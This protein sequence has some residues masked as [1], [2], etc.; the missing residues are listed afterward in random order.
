M[1]RLLVLFLIIALS[2]CAQKEAS[3]GLLTD[4]SYPQNIRYGKDFTIDVLLENNFKRDVKNV[5]I[6]LENLDILNF[7]KIQNCNGKILNNGCLVEKI[8][9]GDAVELNFLLNAPKEVYIPGKD[10][11]VEPKI[12]IS[13][14]F[15]GQTVIKAPII[16]DKYKENKDLKKFITEGPIMVDVS[17]SHTEEQNV[18]R[19][20]SI[21]VM[22]VN[23][24]DSENENVIKKD[25]FNIKLE[26]F[27]VYNSG[28]D[29]GNCDFEIASTTQ[30][31][32]LLKLKEDYPLSRKET[33]ECMLEAESVNPYEWKYGQITIDYRY[34]YNVVNNLFIKVS[35]I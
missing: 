15:D 5:L 35:A 30:E 16:G 8:E 22:S 2:G 10:L 29:E 27:H 23:I 24:Q 28:T 31:F 14:D 26:S 33:L 25:D 34:N 9:P 7:K 4:V 20:N 18:I 3:Y 21:F 32:Q 17:F 11:S 6:N 13:Y 12:T 1:K 19:S